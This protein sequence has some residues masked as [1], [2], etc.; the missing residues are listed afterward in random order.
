MRHLPGWTATCRRSFRHFRRLYPLI[1]RNG[2]RFTHPTTHVAARF[3]SGAAPQLTV[4]PEQPL[5]RDLKQ[6][7]TGILALALA[8]ATAATPQ[9][10]LTLDDV[11]AALT[12]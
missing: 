1:Y 9:L 7:G 3:I 4:G 2:S 8:V 6:I 10:V 5:E 11:H 12:A